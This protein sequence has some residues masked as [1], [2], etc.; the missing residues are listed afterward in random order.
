MNKA[1]KTIRLTVG[2]L[3]AVGMLDSARAASTDAS[4]LDNSQV[5]PTIFGATVDTHLSANSLALYTP[6][7]A[8]L[9]GGVTLSVSPDLAPTTTG[10]ALASPTTSGTTGLDGLAPSGI[11]AQVPAAVPVPASAWL[12][13]SGLLGL[14]G[15][16]R[17]RQN[18]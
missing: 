1:L 4:G 5:A 12:L 10:S 18:G 9:T 13:G 16:S 2:V 15:I 6:G 14:V 8:A 7:V 11:T 17:R 3:T